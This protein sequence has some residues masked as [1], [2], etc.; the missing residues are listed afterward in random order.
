VT[1]LI[2]HGTIVRPSL[3]VALAPDQLTERLGL[4]GVL[5]MRVDPGGPAARAGL[6]PTR[7]DLRGNVHLGDL[8][9]G[10]DD[11]ALESTEDFFAALEK[12]APGDEVT[13]TVV[14]DG[15]PTSVPLTLGREA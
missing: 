2:R 14:R 5:V 12:R 8:I 9:V 13:L 11:E 10:I 4:H 3:G 6:R 1:E 15:E 7:R